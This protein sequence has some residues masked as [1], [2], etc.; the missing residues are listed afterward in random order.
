MSA[1]TRSAGRSKEVAITRI[2]YHRSMNKQRILFSRGESIGHHECVVKAKL[3]L[4]H[5][6]TRQHSMAL[7]K[8]GSRLHTTT[9]QPSIAGWQADFKSI[10][11]IGITIDSVVSTA[12]VELTNLLHATEVWSRTNSDIHR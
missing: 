7:T 1:L 9:K 6:F 8:I 11:A 12:A 3:V 2:P 5:T 10:A 4:P